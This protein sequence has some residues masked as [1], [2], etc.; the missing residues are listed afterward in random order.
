MT[1]SSLPE[2]THESL[3]L[4]SYWL[5]WQRR[6][7]PAVLIFGTVFGLTAAI[8]T[9]QKPV[10]EA[11]GKLL[12]NK[13]NR[14]SALTGLAEQAGEL[15]SLTQQSNP[16][17][18]EVEIIRSTPI[19]QK[20][21]AALHLKDE[22]GK[23]MATE[24]FVQKLRVKS[25]HGIDIITL[26]YQSTNP[27]EAAAVVKQVTQLYLNNNVVNTRAE[28]TAA[29]E[30]ISKQLPNVEAK[31]VQAEATL[32]QFQEQNQVVALAEEAKSA[33]TVTADLEKQLTLAQ[34]ELADVNTRASSLQAEI[35]MDAQQAIALSTLS[36][37]EGV[38]QVLKEYQKVQDELAVQQTR[39]RDSHPA[40][41]NLKHKAEALQ[42][43][44]QGRVGETLHN[45][46]V[47]VGQDLQMSTLE[48]NLA[49]EL[50]KSEVERR[51]LANR[52]V[53]LA[54]K[55]A[56]YRSRSNALP[57]LSET[58][59]Q[60][61]RQVQIAQST[62]E[63][64]FKRLQEVKVVENQNVGN[65]RII[66]APVIPDR[67][68][69]PR[70]ALNLALGGCLG[71]ILAVVVALLLETQDRSV[72]TVEETKQLLGFTFL[73]SIPQFGP[74]KGEATIAELPVRDNPYSLAS[75]AYE[76]LQVNLSFSLPD[77]SFKV[78]VL[79]SAL[80]GEGKST[81]AA[82]LAVAIA[83]MGRQVLL[84]DGDM[85]RPRQ[86]L[87]WQQANLVGLSDVLIGQAKPT[88]TVQEVMINLDLLPCG[89]IPPNA[90]VLLD[91]QGLA[92][93]IK[94]FARSY[95]VVIIDTPPL[96]LVPDALILGKHADGTVLV[97]R[98][99]VLDSG[100]AAKART[101]LAQSAQRVLGLVANGTHVQHDPDNYAYRYGYYGKSNQH[102][103]SGTMSHFGLRK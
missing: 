99:G 55:Y 16:L 96:T 69:S 94:D 8:T 15:S 86:H 65:A 84:I 20:T 19:S 62:Y 31:M 35:G 101:L 64:L 102:S 22:Q 56:E 14:L 50:V 41:V 2:V 43:Q 74:P 81:V 6:W 48:Q 66:S 23:K 67:P 34:A 24:Q 51:G 39:Y 21:I 30:F 3:N 83:Q 53:V 40:I 36:Q 85:R 33:V 100:S 1:A 82:N 26:S 70:V 103:S 80:P 88:E 42:K 91:S 78:I 57:R 46:P 63:Q 71:C 87:L 25:T 9:L 18:T 98:P 29:R 90:A 72:K 95:D 45:R 61:E 10:Y 77:Q 37:S 52:A 59:R 44:L 7:V 17:A 47:A 27:Q 73:G 92:T 5:I 4:Q 54:N 75:A 60:L 12:L 93:L 13:T 68:V 38:Q 58:Q 11:E 79:T 76:M 28:A 32:R 97:A 89:T 49:Q